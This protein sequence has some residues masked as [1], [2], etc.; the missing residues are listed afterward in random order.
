MSEKKAGPRM[1][2]Q[3]RISKIRKKSMLA[4]E[5]FQVSISELIAVWVDKLKI[6]IGNIIRTRVWSDF[7]HQVSFKT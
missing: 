4:S 6:T 5:S 1:K 3:N 7:G 2:A